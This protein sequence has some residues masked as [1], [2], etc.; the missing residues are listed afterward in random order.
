M[1]SYVVAYV[2]AE[3]PPETRQPQNIQRGEY[4][5]KISV[6][7]PKGRKNFGWGLR[8]SKKDKTKPVRFKAGVNDC[9]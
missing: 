6:S 1:K 7:L 8:L 5:A 4:K 9:S 3:N 2:S